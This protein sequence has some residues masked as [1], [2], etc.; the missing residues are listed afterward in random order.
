MKSVVTLEKGI[1]SAGT[2][3]YPTAVKK[4]MSHHQG[5]FS[6][7]CVNNITFITH[8]LEKPADSVLFAP[9]RHCV[10]HYI[11]QNKKHAKS[12]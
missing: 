3:S 5:L 11:M 12:D 9:L 4:E 1:P 7:D 2:S 10:E 6:V 8:S